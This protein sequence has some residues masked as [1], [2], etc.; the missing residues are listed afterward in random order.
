MTSGLG[1][2]QALLVECGF[3]EG[4]VQSLRK[5]FA[6]NKVFPA[7]RSGTLSWRNRRHPGRL[8]IYLAE[9][10]RAFPERPGLSGGEYA[11]TGDIL[12]SNIFQ[13]PLLDVDLETFSGRFRNYDAYCASLLKLAGDY[14][15]TRYCPATAR[16][17]RAWM[18]PSSST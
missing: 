18:R 17:W 11:V 4:F 16:M 14:G 9:L 12:L 10:P 2:L 5:T 15:A 6:E 8:G 7:C 1:H 3:D 13:A